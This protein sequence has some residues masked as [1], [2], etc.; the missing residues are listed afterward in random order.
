MNGKNAAAPFVVAL[1][2]LVAAGCLESAGPTFISEE[3]KN[4]GPSGEDADNVGQT[5]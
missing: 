4:P 5:S 3:N 1:R 2:R